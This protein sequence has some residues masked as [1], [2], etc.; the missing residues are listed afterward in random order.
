[1]FKA[2]FLKKFAM[3]DYN[4]VIMTEL[5]NFKMT[6]AIKEY[7]AAYKDLPDQAPN[8]INF[9]KAGPQLDFYSGL[10]THI[11]QQ[12]DMTHCKGLQDAFLEEKCAA[13]KYDS[14]HVTNRQKESPTA[15]K[16]PWL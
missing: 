6:G 7:I 9:D 5:R 10:P 16:D 3:K 12:F 4:M 14:L 13:Q 11:R 15:R 8:T 1:M 2:A